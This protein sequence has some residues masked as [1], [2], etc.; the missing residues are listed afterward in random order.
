MTAGP[1]GEVEQ[2]G[3]MAADEP[4][5]AP[6]PV[7][8]TVEAPEAPEAPPA[9]PDGAE[10]G[11]GDDDGRDD[12][13]DHRPSAPRHRARRAGVRGWWDAVVDAPAESWIGALVTAACVAFV[14][15]QLQ[16]DLL[17]AKTTP[18]GGDMG[19]HV[20]GPAYLRDH[21]LPEWRLTG[22][23]PDWYAGFPAFQFYMLPPALL[24]LLLDVVLP[25]GIAMKLVTV[26]GVVALPLCAYVMG[27]LLRMPFPAPPLL[28]VATVPFLF[29]RSWTIYGGNVASTLAGEYSFSISLSLALLF[30]GVLGRGL[31]TGRHRGLA[32]VLLALTILCHAIPAFFAVIGGAVLVLLRIDRR[33]VLFAAPVLVLGCL[34]TAFWSVPFVLRRGY[35]T[36]MGWEKLEG[37]HDALLPDSTR[38]V[39]VL[40][41][42]GVVLSVAFWIRAGV[43]FAAVAALFAGGFLVDAASPVHIWN[44]RLLP[45]YYLCLYLLA[46]IGVAEVVR[47]LAIIVDGRREWR[48][49]FTEGAGAVGA[50]AAALILV[51]L[52]LRVL[53]GGST[54]STGEYEWLFLSTRDDSF[55]DSWATWNY[56]GYERKDSYPE[57]R[58]IMATMQE[59]GEEEGCGRAH[60]EYEE[61]LNRYG[62]PMAMML[63]PFWTDGCIGSM[64][65][66]YFES[67]GT[68]PFHFLN[69]AETSVAPSNPV[70]SFE[71]RPMP[72]SPFDL[73]RGVEH[74][75]LLGVRYYLAFSDQAV[76]AAGA[77]P[78]LTEVAT[79]PP[80]HVYEIADAELVEPLRYEPA[81]LE[82]MEPL[83]SHAWQKDAVE[84]YVDAEAMEVVLAP[85]GPST[86]QR[87]ERGQ[88]PD[89]RELDR[90]QVRDI[91]EDDL[92]IS[93]DVDRTGVPVLVKTSYFPNW[94][95]SGADGPYRVTPNLMV[96][97]PTEE[98]VELS[99]GYT[100]VEYLG[101]GLTAA[102]AAGV[103]FLA[104][105]GPVTFPP[106]RR[107]RLG[108]DEDVRSSS[109][110]QP[111]AWPPP[112]GN[113][114]APDPEPI[115]FWDSLLAERKAELAQAD[116]GA[117]DAPGDGGAGRPALL[118]PDG[119]LGDDEPGPLRP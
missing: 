55:V 77:H 95:V 73:D 44:A 4:R 34:L 116:Q 26:A 25:Y 103:G 87:V 14:V 59:V 29:D 47:S 83:D 99:Y 66:L 88:D 27:R 79:S 48:R 113:G 102:A 16:P 101:Y 110:W 96:V 32:T 85:E 6:G 22:W 78:D 117:E 17:V 119:E 5:D 11:A 89:R 67:S 71:D 63:L 76:A 52:P 45:F 9:D 15:A 97:V 49:R 69:A 65:G 51:A 19:A 7:T 118:D 31:E 74:L 90:V 94:E 12:R 38:W 93:F 46:A 8:A 115:G 62:T 57:Y 80:W 105:R 100:S 56:S 112:D 18:A 3:P 86:W 58:S 68:T 92:S 106:S 10:G 50:L 36:D 13:L 64:E 28:A 75:Q 53:P 109:G 54:S 33:R 20:W 107:R 61:D 43:F 35:L 21:L 42:V 72:Y 41:L 82:G 84:W 23:T 70:R 39:L 98:H 104:W 91:E 108:G 30:F 2:S 24:I 1:G 40:A 114:A 60:W 111:A 37:Y 81:V